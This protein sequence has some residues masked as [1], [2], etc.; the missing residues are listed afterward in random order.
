MNIGIIGTIADH[1]DE[2]TI[3]RGKTEVPGNVHRVFF[4]NGKLSLFMKDN[5]EESIALLGKYIYATVS[6][7]EKNR[8]MKYELK[9][10]QA[11]Q[12]RSKHS[13]LY[14]C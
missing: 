3:P 14:S 13:K 4:G 1:F 6:S 12:A 5:V 11:A 9:F 7:P 8:F 2:L 10:I